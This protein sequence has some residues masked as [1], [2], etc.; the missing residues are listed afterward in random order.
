[1]EIL[2][3]DRLQGVESQDGQVDVVLELV[4]VPDVPDHPA[5]DQ[6]GPAGHGG[7]AKGRDGLCIRAD[8]K[9]RE[10]G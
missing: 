5:P 6:K 4:A 2:G 1:M 9:D 3:Q 8:N 7:P 10:Y